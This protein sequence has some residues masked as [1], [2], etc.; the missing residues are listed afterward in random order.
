[1]NIFVEVTKN[2]DLV[3]VANRLTLEKLLRLLKCCL[4]LVNFVR[5]CVEYEAVG[6]PAVVSPENQDLRIVVHREAAQGVSRR[7]LLVLV[8]KRYHLPLLILEGP[9]APLEAV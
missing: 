5:L 7:P 9:W 8:D 2:E 1:M 3:I 4:M 6:D